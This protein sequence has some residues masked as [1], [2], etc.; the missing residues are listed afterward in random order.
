[1]KDSGIREFQVVDSDVEFISIEFRNRKE[2]KQIQLRNLK[3]VRIWLGT[4]NSEELDLYGT[5]ARR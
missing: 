5:D 4:E 1:M 2:I 3:D